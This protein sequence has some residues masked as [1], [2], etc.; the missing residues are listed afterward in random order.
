MFQN[1]WK[2]I[3]ILKAKYFYVWMETLREIKQQKK[4][5]MLLKKKI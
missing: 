5:K 2:D 4:Y 1:F 3:E